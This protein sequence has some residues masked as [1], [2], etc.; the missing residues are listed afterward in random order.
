MTFLA[1]FQQDCAGHKARIPVR[2]PV[3]TRAE[4]VLICIGLCARPGVSDVTL[5]G[6]EAPR[7]ASKSQSSR[8]VQR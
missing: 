8:R 6:E 5:D 3:E 7:S 4:A 2:I 1:S